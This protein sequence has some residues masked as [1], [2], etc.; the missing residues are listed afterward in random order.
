VR[1]GP[2]VRGQQL[3]AQLDVAREVQRDLL[4]APSRWPTGMD[5]AASCVPASD[6]GGDFYD[7]VRLPGGRIAFVLGDV[8]GHGLPA[9]LLMGLV[10]GAMSSPAW[11][12]GDEDPAES[13]ARLNALLLQKSSGE[14]FASL[15]WCAYDPGT[16]ALEYVNAGHI[17]PLW[18]R[19][20]PADTPIV[21]RLVDGGPVLGLLDSASY[22]ATSIHT[23]AGDLLVL[24]S[25]GLVE[26]SNSRGDFFGE[27]RLIAIAREHFDR[28]AHRIVD[29]ILSGVQAFAPERTRADDQT[30]LV[31]R[32]ADAEQMLPRLAGNASSAHR[33]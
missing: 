22:R 13:A 31:V 12:A 9:A 30:L 1:L 19:P 26:V 16:G 3:Q 7:V 27:E 10:H 21:E 15:F 32:L 20:G 2:Y 6:V 28:G 25:D 5:I 33:A 14:R 8:S 4:P 18:I 17:P 23:A 24:F 29:G 11:G